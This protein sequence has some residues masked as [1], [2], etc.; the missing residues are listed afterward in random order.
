MV[1][2][3]IMVVIIRERESGKKFAYAYCREG[4]KAN[5][6][7]PDILAQQNG[8]DDNPH[9]TKHIDLNDKFLGYSGYSSYNS[10]SDNNTK[11]VREFD[12][13]YYLDIIG[14]ITLSFKNYCLY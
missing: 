12:S 1:M 2:L 9:K 3:I 7:N 13:Q 5:D 8:K 11:A 4:L 14:T 6:L 10:D